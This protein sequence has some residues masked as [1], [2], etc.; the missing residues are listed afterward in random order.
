V[1]VIGVL[2]NG[3]TMLNV[4]SYWQE[5]VKGIIILIAVLIDKR[6]GKKT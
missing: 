5:V 1:I 3:L 6:A 4:S 2:S